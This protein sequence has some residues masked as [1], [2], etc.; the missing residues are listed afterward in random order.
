MSAEH[1][2]ALQELRKFRA[3]AMKFQ[4]RISAFP[5]DARPPA[6]HP[7]VMMAPA[8]DSREPLKEALS[9]LLNAIGI[10]EVILQ[11]GQ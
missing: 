7:S 2:R 8:I 5:S 6:G 9:T 3:Q 1:Q 4:G 11:T 10:Y